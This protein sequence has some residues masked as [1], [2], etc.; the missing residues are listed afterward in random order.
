MS[1]TQHES[2]E[3]PRR[4]TRTRAEH[5]AANANGLLLVVRCCRHRQSLA[6]PLAGDLQPVQHTIFTRRRSGCDGNPDGTRNG[7]NCCP[8]V[9]GDVRRS[10]SR[11]V[12]ETSDASAYQCDSVSPPFPER[13]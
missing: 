9:H 11:F 3:R 6:E 7:N 2:G 10:S 5:V 13:A 1:L 12:G 8:F 4:R